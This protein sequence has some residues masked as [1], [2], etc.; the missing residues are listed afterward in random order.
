MIKP[1]RTRKSKTAVINLEEILEKTEDGYSVRQETTKSKTKKSTKTVKN[2]EEKPKKK[3]KN[4]GLDFREVERTLNECV[5]HIKVENTEQEKSLSLI[6]EDIRLVSLNEIFANL[7]TRPYEI[8]KY[9]KN[10]H[11]LISKVLDSYQGEIPVFKDEKIEITYFR[12]ASRFFD[13]DSLIPSFKYFLDSLVDNK[14]IM[15]DDPNIVSD[16][17]PIQR[18]KGKDEKRLLGIKIKAI[19]Q[20]EKNHKPIDDIYLEWGFKQIEGNKLV[21]TD[22]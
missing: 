7:Q 14:V 15:D 5:Y 12:Q 4:K 20:S 13:H 1:T 18:I 11:A 19:K 16:I 21:D 9:K 10:C 8:F 17:R 3:K 6:L 2:K 22:M